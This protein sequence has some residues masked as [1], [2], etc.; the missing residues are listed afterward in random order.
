MAKPEAKPVSAAAAAIPRL[1]MAADELLDEAE[2]LPASPLSSRQKGSS[3]K[4][5]RKTLPGSPDRLGGPNSTSKAEGGD[6]S[7]P[8]AGAGNQNG[9]SVPGNRAASPAPEQLP[10]PPPRPE[11]GSPAV[12][13]RQSSGVKQEHSPVTGRKRSRSSSLRAHSGDRWGRACW[14]EDMGSV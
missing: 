5:Q 13:Q 7:S 3:Q 14:A 4:R 10:G 8:A 1:S 12:K 11:S 9:H 2:A 6:P